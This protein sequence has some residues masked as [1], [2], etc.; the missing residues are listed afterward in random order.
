MF[1]FDLIPMDSI[2]NKVQK[3]GVFA[4]LTIPFKH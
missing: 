2:K 1:K 4:Q 3:M